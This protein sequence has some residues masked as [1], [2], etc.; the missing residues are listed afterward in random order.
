MLAALRYRWVQALVVTLLSAL[1]TGSLAFAPLYVR[2]VDQAVVATILDDTPAQDAGVSVVSFS[3]S[4]PLLATSFEAQRDLIPA[5]LREVLAPGIPS[6]FVGVRRMPLVDQP[7]G[8][9]LWREGMCEHLRFTAGRCPHVAGQ[10]AISADQARAYRMSVGQQ[11]ELGEW[12]ASVSRVEAAPWTSVTITGIY[13]AVPGPYWFGEPL[14]GRAAGDLGY[15]VMLAAQESLTGRVRAP[16]SGTA[17]WTQLHYGLD[18]PLRTERVTAD[19]IAGVGAVAA[20]WVSYPMGVER[21]GTAVSDAVHVRTLLPDL[22]AQARASSDQAG[23]T[24]AI[25]MAQL[26]LLLSAV[27]WLVLLAGADQRRAEVAIARLRGRG[28]GGA[29]RL[30]LSETLPAVVVGVPV[31]VLVAFGMA[32]A[33]R[34]R[35]H[36]P[37]VAAEFP[38]GTWYAAGLALA[39]M[40]ALAVLSVRAVVRAPIAELL[41]SVPAERAKVGLGLLEAMI[42]AGAAGVVIALVTGAIQGPVAQVAPALLAVAV[43]VLAARLVPAALAWLGRWWLGRGAARPGAALLHASRR[44]ATRWLIPIVTV[45]LALVVLTADLLAIGAVNRQGRAEAEIGAPTVLTLAEN[46]LRT[47]AAAIQDIDPTGTR[48]TPVAIV[49]SAGG[50]PATVGV[51]PGGFRSIAL[52]PGIQASALPWDRLTGPPMPPLVLT[53]TRLT[54]H[55][56]MPPVSSSGVD[57]TAVT[58]AL[59]LALQIVRPDGALDVVSIGTLRTKGQDGTDAQDGERSAAVPC[60][61]GCQV[62]GIGLTAP[63]GAAPVRGEVTISELACDGVPFTLGASAD[64][65]GPPEAEVSGTVTGQSVTID[66]AN[67]GLAGVFLRHASLPEVLPALTTT[68]AASSDPRATIGGNL[69]DGS[70]QLLRGVGSVPYLPGAPPRAALVHLDNLMVHGWQGR[71]S[72]RLLAY[73]AASD[74]ASVAALIADLAG[75]GIAVSASAHPADRVAVFERTGATWSLELSAVVAFLALAITAVALLILSAATWR[76]RTRDY[77]GLRMA[78]LNRRDIRVIALLETLPVVL[79]AGIL[80]VATGLWSAP[81]A[82]PVVPLFTTPPAAYPVDLGTRYGA[83]SAAAA[84]GLLALSLIAIAASRFVALGSD[85][86][87]LREG[88]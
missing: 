72:T 4:D 13:E 26:G 41:Q 42:V 10:V 15:D 20:D 40:L 81:A 7:E 19:T 53:G 63:L 58:S 36:S 24:V 34:C 64:W 5:G 17:S 60:D 65:R 16:G 59:G 6:V 18:L 87:R 83:A 50:V 3:T 74:P 43:G 29:R 23:I 75:R 51:D 86:E 84:G 55:A 78:G 30:L 77:A 21:F 61:L 37:P 47:V 45:A 33:A 68:S 39:G 14:T 22:A 73:A 35:L 38:A 9:L 44:R 80:G 1:V 25:L 46:D 70:D 56:T 85:L 52:W 8:R 67:S 62:V 49:D 2:A 31:G 28:R 48:V 82:A 69:I 66:F 54:Y 12:D 71:G 11:I 32:A 27:L 57:P 79:V 76:A 88:G